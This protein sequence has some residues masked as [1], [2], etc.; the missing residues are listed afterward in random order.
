MNSLR[1]R[2]SLLASSRSPLASL[3]SPLA[4]ALWIAK[5]VGWDNVPRRLWQSWVMRSGLL[6]RRSNPTEY[7]WDKFPNKGLTQAQRSEQWNQRRQRFFAIPNGD[8]LRELVTPEQWRVSVTDVCEQAVEG[9]YPFFSRWHGELGW[10]PNFN[11]D[12]VNN[13]HWPV[14]EHWLNTARSGPPRNDIK[15]V[16]EASRCALAFDLARQHVYSNDDVW[17]ERLWQ[18]IDA[19][20]AQNPVN[21][22]VAWACGQETAFRLMALLTAVMATFD[23]SSTTPERLAQFELLCWQSAKRIEANINYA[24]SQEN[25][26]ALSEA[27]G[28]WTVGLLFPEFPEAKR[29][30]DLG[31]R[32]LESEVQRQIYGDGSYVQHSM[33]YHRVMLDDLCWAIQL[34]R[35]QGEEFSQE[36]LQRVAA[37]TEWLSQFVDRDNGRVPNYGSNDGANILPLACGDYLDYRPTLQLA[38]VVSGVDSGLGV[39]PWSEKTLWLTG[40]VPEPGGVPPTAETWQAEQ[41]GYFV[42]RGPDSQLMTRATEYRDRPG[43]CDMLHVDLWV[44]GINILRDAGSFRYY[45]EDRKIKNYFYS[46]TAHNTVQVG[47]S[48]QMTKGPNF[49]WFHWPKARGRFTSPTEL[50]CRAEFSASIRYVHQRDIRRAGD[51]YCVID[52]VTGSDRFTARWRLAPELTWRQTQPNKVVAGLPGGGDIEISFRCQ[53]AEDCLVSLSEAWESLYYGE[54]SLCPAVTVSDAR[55]ELETKIVVRGERLGARGEKLEARG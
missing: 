53:A 26:H 8:Q 43:Q 46:V 35:R 2:R 28:L 1:S 36:L 55:G 49:L 44:H 11:L 31:R 12:P 23:C 52:Q 54:R 47:D 25:N 20:I 15:L 33:S 5:G 42:M 4:S 7:G 32:V 34:G 39:G 18:F 16:W 24:I 51:N 41:G 27:T 17:A 22:S 37:A 6:R 19:W 38:A 40:K 30:C 14:G 9:N 10:P 29:W 50:D 21:H 45:H 48:E 13:I 3:L